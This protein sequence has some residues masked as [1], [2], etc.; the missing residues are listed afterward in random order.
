MQVLNRKKGDEFVKVVVS[1]VW[2][3]IAGI[4]IGLTP[5]GDYITLDGEL[6]QDP[7]FFKIIEPLTERKKAEAWWVR[8]QDLKKAKAE[9][10]AEGLETVETADE[11]VGGD[12]L[13]KAL[14]AGVPLPLGACECPGNSRGQP[15]C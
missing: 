9:A 1:R 5:E 12:S 14:H 3:D 11:K 10:K 8:Q 2:S 6:V 15:M 13:E 4:Q 7:A